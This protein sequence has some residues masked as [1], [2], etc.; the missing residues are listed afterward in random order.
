MVHA[1]LERLREICLALPE[2]TEKPFGG[3]TA[4][5]WRVRDKIFAMTAAEE[6]DSEDLALWC[7]APPGAQEVLVG[8]DPERYFVPPY[9]G[10]NGWVGVRLEGSVDWDLLG[11]L[12]ADSYRMTA[13][14]RLASQ[15][16]PTISNS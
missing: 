2:A 9:V 6:H 14:K 4:P 5:A 7:K 10:H 1:A 15:V 11:G 13:P 12:I 3:H 8:G 16:A